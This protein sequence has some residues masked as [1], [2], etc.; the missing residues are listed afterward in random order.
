MA[1]ALAQS[2]VSRA[3]INNPPK[4]LDPQKLVQLH[5]TDQR[6][7]ELVCFLAYRRTDPRTVSVYKIADGVSWTMHTTCVVLRKIQH[8]GWGRLFNGDTQ[9]AFFVFDH[10]MLDVAQAIMRRAIAIEAASIPAPLQYHQ[11]ERY[12]T[13]TIETR[14]VVDLAQYVAKREGHTAQLRLRKDFVCDITLPEDLTP[15]ETQRL[16]S[17]LDALTIT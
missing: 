10:S 7:R 6:V 3:E 14:Q 5:M 15:Q 11:P 16:H 9:Q 12:I 4:P 8:L 17:F 2:D 13:G 1:S